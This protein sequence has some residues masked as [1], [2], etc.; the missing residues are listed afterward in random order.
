VLA[1]PQ[2]RPWFCV[3]RAHNKGE[4][5]F[6]TAFAKRVPGDSPELVGLDCHLNKDARDCGELHAALTSDLPT[7]HPDK[8][9]L[10]TYKKLRDAYMRLLHPAN[11]SCSCFSESQ[12]FC[13]ALPSK[14][15]VEDMIK[16]FNAN[17]LAII[18][19]YGVVVEGLGNRNGHRRERAVWELKHE[20][21]GGKR[22][23]HKERVKQ[24]KEKG[25]GG[26]WCHPCARGSWGKIAGLGT[27]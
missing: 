14:R 18:E 10:T 2:Y 22:I 5:T 3:H 11:G 9:D 16:C 7:G 19:A 24:I 8:F 20:R 21:R 12:C 17:I 4:W 23:T 1:H 15:I 26:F 13:S 25:L 6:S 27:D